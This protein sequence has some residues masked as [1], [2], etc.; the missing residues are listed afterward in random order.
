[1]SRHFARSVI[2]YMLR[3]CQQRA[4]KWFEGGFQNI[5]KMAIQSQKRKQKKKKFLHEVWHSS[6]NIHSVVRSIC[7][8]HFMP[9]EVLPTYYHNIFLVSSLFLVKC[10]FSWKWK[11]VFKNYICSIKPVHLVSLWN[12]FWGRGFSRL[13]FIILSFSSLILWVSIFDKILYCVE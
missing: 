3:R 12:S 1:M 11:I 13:I 7:C 6:L 9:V 5:V 10:I 4:Q 2:R 8:P